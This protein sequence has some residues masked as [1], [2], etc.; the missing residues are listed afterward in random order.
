MEG[1]KTHFGL[2]QK[3]VAFKRM[4]ANAAVASF[5]WTYAQF[6][7]D[8]IAQEGLLQESQKGFDLASRHFSVIFDTKSGY[9]EEHYLL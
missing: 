1:G 8:D 5:C 9:V 3:A 2:G 7:S 4:V 6:T